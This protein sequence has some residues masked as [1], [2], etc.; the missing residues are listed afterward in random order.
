MEKTRKNFC[1]MRF[2]IMLPLIILGVFGVSAIV[3]LLW[4]WI[5]PSIFNLS[6][7]TYWQA[8]GLL[9]L[10]RILFGGFGCRNHHRAAHRHLENHAPFKDKFMDMNDDERQKF[11]SLW[12]QKCCNQPNL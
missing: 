6:A 9:A 10:S 3:M 2:C 1:R 7:I 5:L 8:M 11:K 12:K 4:N